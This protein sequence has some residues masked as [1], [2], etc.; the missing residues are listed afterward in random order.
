MAVT[1][2]YGKSINLWPT[3]IFLPTGLITDSRTCIKLSTLATPFDNRF[4][5]PENDY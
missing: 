4:L 3:F 2:S 5:Y 1:A